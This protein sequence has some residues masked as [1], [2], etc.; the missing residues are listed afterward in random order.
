MPNDN[1]LRIY[2]ICWEKKREGGNDGYTF[3]IKKTLFLCR[4]PSSALP[5]SS[6]SPSLPS[7]C[8]PLS[9]HLLSFGRRGEKIKGGLM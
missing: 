8:P 4:L 3:K 2:D 6:V 1:M 7:L 9:S 5:L